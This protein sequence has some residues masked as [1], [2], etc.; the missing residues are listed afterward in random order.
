MSAATSAPLAPALDARRLVLIPSFD[1]GPRLRTTVLEALA[2]WQPVW[3]VIDGSTDGSAR[4]LDPLLDPASADYRPGLRVFELP[5]NQ[6]KGA[7]LLHGLTAAHQAGFT[8]ILAMDADGQ[9]P[10]DRIPDF[11]RRSAAAPGAMILGRPIFDASA[12]ALRVNGRKVS[13]FWA[14]LETLWHGIDDS[15]FGFRVYPVA[16]LLKVMTASPWMRRY[17]FDVEAAVR[18]DWDGVRPISVP[19][20]VR[21]L[22]K[23]EGGIS[24]FH[25]LRDN[26]LLSWMHSRLLAGFVRRLPRLLARR[27]AERHSPPA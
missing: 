9:H 4:L 27:A 3:V 20:P 1:T 23:D 8:H 12:P 6:G 2:H 19:T 17:D 22:G 18:L 14:N 25:Y 16:P 11:M 10:A 15:L 13:N 5:V 21:Y 26:L 7:A 24:H